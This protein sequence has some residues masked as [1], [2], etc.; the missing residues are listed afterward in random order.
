MPMPTFT[1]CL[2]FVREQHGRA[3]E[4]MEM[5]I[6]HFPDS[7]II[8]LES[9]GPGEDEPEGTIKQARF[10]LNGQEFRAMDSAREHRFTFTPALSIFVQCE[11][12][13]EINPPGLR[14]F[15]ASGGRGAVLAVVEVVAVRRSAHMQKAAT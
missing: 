6:S 9:Y 11:T 10:S 3:D 15:G 13:D 2:M 12:D 14:C 4:A 7:R 5:N 8:E 1:P